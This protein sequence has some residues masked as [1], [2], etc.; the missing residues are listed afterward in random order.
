MDLALGRVLSD[1][2]ALLK[3][4]RELGPLAFD[5]VEVVLAELPHFCCTLPLNSF[6]LP[7]DPS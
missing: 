7:S 3:P 2:I 6:Q 1:A 4:T 5:H